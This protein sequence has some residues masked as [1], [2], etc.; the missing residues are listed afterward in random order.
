MYF[1]SLLLYV[2]S[3]RKQSVPSNHHPTVKPLKAPALPPWATTKVSRNLNFR[4]RNRNHKMRERKQ[5]TT[6]KMQSSSGM[7]LKR[8]LVK[9]RESMK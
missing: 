8:A 2:F 9:S 6:R 5:P 1:V 7:H 4:N 3:R